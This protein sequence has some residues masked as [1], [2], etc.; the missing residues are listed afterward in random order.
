MK[1]DELKLKEILLRENYVS[2]QDVAAAEASKTALLEYV[3]SKN[4][5]T[6]DLL[7][8]AIAESFSIPYADLNSK[9]PTPGQVQKIPEET[10]KK[11]R[12]VVFDENE[13][14]ITFATDAPS[15]PELQ[16][17]LAALFPKKKVALAY[18]LEEDI[19]ASFLYYQKSLDTRFSKMP[20]RNL[21]REI[22]MQ[23]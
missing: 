1:F 14:L 7:G 12:V 17:Q 13:K 11:L 6:K 18:G 16:K 21:K 9:P 8:Q 22:P 5:L 19:D 23:S 20:L 4:I 2:A 3:L 15:N 10:A